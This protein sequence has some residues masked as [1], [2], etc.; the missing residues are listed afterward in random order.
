[1][2]IGASQKI[3]REFGPILLD[4]EVEYRLSQ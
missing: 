3:K 2:K 1:L 4:I